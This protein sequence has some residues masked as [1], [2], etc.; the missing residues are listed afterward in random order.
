MI[1]LGLLF[2][3]SLE[4][5]EVLWR[6]FWWYTILATSCHS[7]KPIFAQVVHYWIPTEVLII[8]EVEIQFKY[9]L[10]PRLL[11]LFCNKWH[12]LL[13]K[14]PNL[15]RSLFSKVWW[16]LIDIVTMNVNSWSNYT[17][18]TCD[19][20]MTTLAYIMFSCDAACYATYFSTT[21]PC[22][23]CSL[24]TW[25][26]QVSPFYDSIYVVDDILADEIKFIIWV[27]VC[28]TVFRWILVIA[29]LHNAFYLQPAPK[30]YTVW[31]SS[32]KSDLLY[33]Y[34]Q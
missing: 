2:R 11:P 28:V 22:P 23:M 14:H 26:L 12:N 29:Q 20:N 10:H 31:Y 27:K 6:N 9:L 5:M 18:I 13:T 7:T 4:F 19:Y 16:V 21:T 15:V 34:L 3:I 1:F 8:G 33:F 17:D 24:V 32:S 30:I 25:L